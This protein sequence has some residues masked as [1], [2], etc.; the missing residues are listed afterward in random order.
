MLECRALPV[1]SI[2]L[3]MQSQH[4]KILEGNL[5]V[6]KTD[7]RTLLTSAMKS[8]VFYRQYTCWETSAPDGKSTSTTWKW[9]QAFVRPLNS[10]SILK[11]EC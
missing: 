9:L 6:V 2:L 8:P 4:S 7:W 3:G 11:F 10:L 1:F 5:V